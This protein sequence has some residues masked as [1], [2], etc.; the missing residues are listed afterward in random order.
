MPRHSATV[1]PGYPQS[2]LLSSVIEQTAPWGA[3]RV[4]LT[5]Q[6]QE[7]FL[8]SKENAGA[9]VS[10]MMTY[11]LREMT[12]GEKKRKRTKKKNKQK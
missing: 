7:P 6:G 2:L 8:P 4:G 1:I 9:A 10:S 3:G 12:L 5:T 11:P